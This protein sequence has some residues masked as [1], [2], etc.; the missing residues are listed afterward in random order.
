[1]IDLLLQLTSD[2]KHRMSNPTK[3]AQKAI[4][5]LGQKY[6]LSL[7]QSKL[8]HRETRIHTLY[9]GGSRLRRLLD[10]VDVAFAQLGAM[11]EWVAV[12]PAEKLMQL[13]ESEAVYNSHHEKPEPPPN[14]A[15]DT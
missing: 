5:A 8:S 2:W 15:P 6:G 7:N 10:S 13:L 11:G 1:M 3:R 4:A 12:L 14:G 9:A